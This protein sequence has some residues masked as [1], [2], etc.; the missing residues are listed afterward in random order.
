MTDRPILMSAPMV[1][2]SKREAEAPGTGK[3]Q[4]RRILKPQPGG[5]H[6]A[7]QDED[8]GLW[9]TSGHGEA[10]DWGPLNVRFAVGMRLWVRETLFIHNGFGKPL[11]FSPQV[12]E[13]DNA[14]VWSYGADEID[15]DDERRGVPAIHMPRAFSRLTLTV[16]DVRV[17]RLQAISPDDAAAEGLRYLDDGP[18]AGFW[19]VDDTPIC[20]EGS[21]EAYA[22]LW[23]T[24]NGAGAWDLNPWVCVVSFRPELKNIDDAAPSPGVQ[25]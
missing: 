23:E 22:Q 19:I 2:A 1:L 15:A 16:T 17:E 12:R 5:G 10:G 3:T 9:Y 4:T 24:I 18:G 21:V 20:G 8:T 11:G 6:A 13:G 25:P 7:W 14:R